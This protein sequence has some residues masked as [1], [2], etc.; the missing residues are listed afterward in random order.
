MCVDSR[1]LVV[2]T[3][4]L[5]L[6]SSNDDARRC[7]VAVMR[8]CCRRTAALVTSACADVVVATTMAVG[9]RRPTP[10]NGDERR[11]TSETTA[12][13]G[14]R[15]ERRRRRRR[16]AADVRRCAPVVGRPRQWA[17][18]TMTVGTQRNATAKDDDE[19]RAKNATLVEHIKKPDESC[20]SLFMASVEF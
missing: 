6:S 14:R 16:R 10:T 9:E 2:S 11:R 8:P 13:R 5:R 20:C 17:V 15:V 3:S 4:K 1:R 7:R 19:R 12:G 18:R